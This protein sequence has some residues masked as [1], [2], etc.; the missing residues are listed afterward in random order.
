MAAAQPSSRHAL[1]LPPTLSPD[2]LDTLSEL[3][4]VLAKVRAGIQSSSGLTAP[5]GGGTGTTP[6]ANNH[7]NNS[8]GGGSGAGG[9]GG[10]A[11][12]GTGSGGSGGNDAGAGNAQQLSFKDV[13]GA[14]DGI[15]HKL[16]HARA[17]IRALPD[18][19][20]SIDDQQREIAELE[21]RID[22][23]RQLLERLRERGVQFGK[24]N[25]AG[26]EDVKMEM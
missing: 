1:A 18:M 26:G 12:A 25:G 22:R 20:R 4:T 10:A 19:D 8:G 11:S 2:D 7:N 9:H 24:E 21:A 5:G 6:G 23:Q 14:T 15:K 13:P 17:Q 16:Q 3:S